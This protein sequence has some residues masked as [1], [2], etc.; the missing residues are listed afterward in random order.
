MNPDFDLPLIDFGNGQQFNPVSKLTAELNID[1][2]DLFNPANEDLFKLKG[3][4]E[5]EADEDGKFMSGIDPLDVIG[6]IGLCV[7][8][9]LGL[10]EHFLKGFS[11]IGHFGKDVVGGPVQNTEARMD[12]VGHQTLFDGSDKRNASAYG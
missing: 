6:G 8:S 9:L 5:G 7:S 1:G 3:S 2:C 4:P 12:P 11:F 10:S